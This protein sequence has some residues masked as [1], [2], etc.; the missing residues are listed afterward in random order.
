MLTYYLILGLPLD[1]T[2]RDI[3]KRYLDMVRKYPPERD[4]LRFQKITEAYEALKD[5]RKRLESK[6]F[7]GSSVTDS[8]SALLAL[9]DARGSRRIRVGLKELKNAVKKR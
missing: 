6:M 1:A 5:E 3:R 7:M 9:V 4:P 8:E 2:D